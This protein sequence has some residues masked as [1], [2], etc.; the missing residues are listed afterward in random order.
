MNKIWPAL[1]LCAIGFEVVSGNGGAVVGNL[2]ACAGDA[3]ELML[4]L[5]CAYMLWCGLIAVL[6]SAGALSLLNRL[7]QRYCGGCLCVPAGKMR[8]RCTPCAPICPPTCWGLAT[9]LRHRAYGRL[10]K[11]IKKVVIMKKSGFLLF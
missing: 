1:L 11:C 5:L 9:P 10:R 8:L 2:T 3:L 6:E 4:S 7:M